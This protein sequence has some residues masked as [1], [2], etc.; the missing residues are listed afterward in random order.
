MKKLLFLTG[1]QFTLLAL[2]A[3]DYLSGKLIDKQTGTKEIFY[4]RTQNDIAFYVYQT[5]YKVTGADKS[6]LYTVTLT[7]DRAK[8]LLFVSLKPQTGNPVGS[9]ISY[10]RTECGLIFSDKSSLDTSFN[11]NANYNHLFSFT[12]TL[13]TYPILHKLKTFDKKDIV[14][15]P[16][17]KLRIRKHIEA[18][19]NLDLSEHPVTFN[20]QLYK[21][22][23]TLYAN[24]LRFN[25]AISQIRKQIEEDVT[26]LMKD[27]RVEQDVKR[28]EGEKRFGNPHGKGLLVING[29]IYDG[30]FAEGKFA[31]GS[32]L[33]HNEG[34]EYCGQYQGDKKT[35]TGWLKHKNGSYLLGTYVDNVLSTGITLQK[36]K[37]GEIYFGGF[38]G[39]KRTGYGELQ[40]NTGGKYAGE[41]LDDRLVRGYSKEID[42]FGYYT[43][44][45]I[46]KGI[47]TPVDAKTAEEFFGL[48]LS[49]GN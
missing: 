2:Q 30:N 15:D 41:F 5:V 40:N 31:S 8:G 4:D 48:S 36:S 26:R 14:L 19:K 33:L 9:R 10:D 13:R 47:K 7:H 23:D 49:S 16:L 27:K 35:G 39:G 42:P 29:N 32:V 11:I 44:S 43:Y 46:E 6:P 21:L 3:Q 24:H 22:R 37:D 1:L 20:Q 17:T 38:K 18:I 45:R 12:D 28:Y 34:Y 25:E